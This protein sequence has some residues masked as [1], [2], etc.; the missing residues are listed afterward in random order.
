MKNIE[1]WQSEILLAESGELSER[2]IRALERAMTEQ[3]ALATYRDELR[4]IRALT[5]DAEEL[6]SLQD[7]TLQRIM[8]AAEPATSRASFPTIWMPI[9][10]PVSIAATLVIALWV[11]SFLWLRTDPVPTWATRMQATQEYA[12]VSDET[13]EYLL[14][15]LFGELDEVSWLDLEEQTAE[16]IYEVHFW[17][18]S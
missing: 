1:Y 11:G 3:P 4:H 17:E 14:S 6:P 2:R 16:W 18:G 8:Q 7:S 10:K 13:I 9:W 5:H 12:E 15:S